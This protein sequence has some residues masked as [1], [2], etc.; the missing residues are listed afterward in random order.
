M[1]QTLSNINPITSGVQMHSGD[2][3]WQP[4][5]IFEVGYDK[6]VQQQFKAWALNNSIGFKELVGSYK[7][8][9]AASFIVKASDL[10]TIASTGWLGREESILYLDPCYAPASMKPHN[11]RPACLLYGYGKATLFE[12]LALM[13]QLGERVDGQIVELGDWQQVSKD[14]AFKHDGWTFDPSNNTY[15]VAK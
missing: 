2:T 14:E 9:V 6:L 8:Q 11:K 10:K 7:G 5:V 3:K 15:W 1:T 4:Y 12:D 13:H